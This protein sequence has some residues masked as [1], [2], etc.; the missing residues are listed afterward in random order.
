ML[1]DVLDITDIRQKL[2]DIIQS[3]SDSTATVTTIVQIFDKTCLDNAQPRN[4]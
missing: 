2:L 3:V 4:K 1:L